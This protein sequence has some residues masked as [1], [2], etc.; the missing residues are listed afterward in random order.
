MLPW[1]DFV[2]LGMVAVIAGMMNALA[3]GGTLLTFPV[4]TAVGLP[5]V[6]ANVTNTLAL[7]PGT[8]GGTLAQWEEMKTQARSLLFFLPFA[9]LGGL[10]GGILLLNSGEK[11]FRQIVPFLILMASLLLAAQERLRFFLSRRSEKHA[12]NKTSLRWSGAAVFLVAIYGGYFGAGLGV[13]LL[14]ILGLALDETLT[15]LNALKQSIAFCSNATAAIFFVFSGQ[16]V[17][18]VV[19][20]M[21]ACSLFGGWLGGRLARKVKPASFRWIV[22]TIGVIVA[23]IYFIKG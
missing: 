1:Y 5:A 21:A 8:V 17:W 14:S 6:I 20:V 22:V 2:L 12:S 10:I 23:V 18:P 9:V 13:I 11:V 4:L 15:K 3:G 19:L 7:L 16:V